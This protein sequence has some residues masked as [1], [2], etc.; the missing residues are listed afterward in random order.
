MNNDPS[1]TTT[2][3]YRREEEREN[4]SEGHWYLTLSS[5]LRIYQEILAPLQPFTFILE[6]K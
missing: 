6:D 1:L 2:L 5:F 4:L 3:H